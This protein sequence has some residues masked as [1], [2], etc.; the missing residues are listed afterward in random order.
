MKL[1]SLCLTVFALGA[2]PLTAAAFDYGS[3]SPLLAAEGGG[4]QHGVPLPETPT[5]S[6]ARSDTATAGNPETRAGAQVA[7][8]PMAQRIAPSGTNSSSAGAPTGDAPRPSA[9]DTS[10][11]ERRPAPWQSL[12]PGSIQ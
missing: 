12:L 11:A 6:A 2:L 3:N 5:H 9:S 1:P 4:P 10:T 8:P 7:E